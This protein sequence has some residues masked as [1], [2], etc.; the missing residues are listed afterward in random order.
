MQV[1]S[2]IQNLFKINNLY[3]IR[4]CKLISSTKTLKL[5]KAIAFI[6]WKQFG[7]KKD[8]SPSFSIWYWNSDKHYFKI[9]FQH[10]Y[11]FLIY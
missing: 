4:T 7:D 10:S 11:E 8:E 9:N 1:K 5:D 3:E 6:A 2:N